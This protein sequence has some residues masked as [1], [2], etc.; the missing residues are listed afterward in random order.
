M[1]TAPTVYFI[2]DSATMREVIKIAFRRENINVVACHD[3]IS[4]LRAMESNLPDIVIS[5]LIM[6][7]KDGYEVCQFIKQHPRLAK[8]PVILMSGVVNR[9]VAEKAFAVKADE[10]I[11]KPFQPQDL[12]NR[13]KHLLHLPG[14][15]AAAPAP[16]PAAASHALST[17]FAA[18]AAPPAPPANGGAARVAATPRP[19]APPVSTPTPAAVTPAFA[20]AP[21]R[22]AAPPALAQ[23]V[24]PVASPQPTAP[25]PPVATTS[26]RVAAP[27]SPADAQKLKLEIMRLENLVKKLQSELEAEREYSKALEEHVKTLQEGE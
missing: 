2:D 1:S 15:P 10:L 17:I 14:A 3:A 20:T 12:I 11:R 21:A 7:D 16:A 26:P 24:A 22:A 25:R 19:A 13:V 9:T 4:A 6:P 23:P 18:S 8:T 27:G 5:D